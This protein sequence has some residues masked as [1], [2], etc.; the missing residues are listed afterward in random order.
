MHVRMT[1]VWMILSLAAIALM[2]R[3]AMA[4]APAGAPVWRPPAT[5]A[6]PAPPPDTTA[7][8]TATPPDGIGNS[9]LKTASLP[10]QPGVAPPA[11]APLATAPTA[12][13]PLAAV[14]KGNGTL[15]NDQGQVW[16]EYDITSYTLR[17]P[18]TNHAEQAIVDWI[19]RDTGYAAW[20][21]ET[22]A[23]LGAD[24]RTLRVYHTPAMQQTVGEIVDRFV[25]SQAESHAFGVQV[26]TVGSPNWRAM[27]QSMLHPVQVQTAGAQAWLLAK[28]DAAT[29]LVALGRRN[30]FRTHSSPHLLVNNGQSTVITL[31]QPRNYVRGLID[32]D[33]RG[34]LQPEVGQVFDGFSLELSPLL[35]RDGRMIDT[36][37]KCN[38]D[39]IEK[40]IPVKLDVP[41]ATPGL[42]VSN[43]EVPQ[44]SGT[45]LQERF[46]W[47]VDKVLLVSLGVVPAPMPGARSAFSL[48]LTSS[49]TR[50]DVLLLVES[51]GI[52]A[53]QPGATPAAAVAPPGGARFV[54]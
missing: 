30:D 1:H 34:G 26:M 14:T 33:G 40:M 49:P 29:L 6:A 38:I 47:P 45:R 10:P 24:R 51:K 13:A 2:A 32:T 46:R 27:V 7:E 42:Q 4:Q 23:M 28:E 31:G 43:I 12:A 50:A 11:V 39:Q 44:I 3:G 8:R 22:V 36:A 16:R 19:I 21:S 52:V 5:G 53:P 54:R 48:S 25:N 35:S 37:L 18:S 41:A 20:H 9:V 15:P 17:V